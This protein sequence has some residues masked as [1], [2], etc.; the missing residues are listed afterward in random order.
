M[1]AVHEEKVKD[2][3]VFFFFFF[4]FSAV[5]VIRLTNLYPNPRL[6]CRAYYFQGQVYCTSQQPREKEGE[7]QKKGQKEGG[8]EKKKKKRKRGRERKKK[9]RNMKQ[10]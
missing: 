3:F 9:A 2:V 5:E 1:L 6:G 7:R 10:S 8:R 4:F